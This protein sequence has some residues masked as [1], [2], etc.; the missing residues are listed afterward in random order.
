MLGRLALARAQPAA[1]R[2]AVRRSAVVYYE[3]RIVEDE[4]FLFASCQLRGERLA[5]ASLDRYDRARAERKLRFSVEHHLQA[6]CPAHPCGAAGSLT[7]V[8]P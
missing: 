4:R 8:Q 6:G 1:R 2:S 7:I 3:E 5:G